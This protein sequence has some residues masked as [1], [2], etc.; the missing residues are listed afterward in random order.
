M[1]AGVVG[2]W[3]I[4]SF[5]SSVLEGELTC[6]EPAEPFSEVGTV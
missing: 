3:M 5:L 1:S 2:M 6:N 4:V